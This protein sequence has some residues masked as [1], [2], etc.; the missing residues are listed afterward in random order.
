[1][2]QT[3]LKPN[4]EPAPNP[5]ISPVPKLPVKAAVVPPTSNPVPKAELRNWFSN[6]P[7]A[8]NKLNPPGPKAKPA[9]IGSN[10]LNTPPKLNASGIPV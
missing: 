10:D 4:P 3:S 8:P 7:P 5:A 6:I 9:A 1:M 2:F